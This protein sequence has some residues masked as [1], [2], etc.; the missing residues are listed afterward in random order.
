MAGKLARQKIDPNIFLVEWF[1]TI[2]SR[3]FSFET[4]L[5]LWDHLLYFGEV[6][7]YRIALSIMELIR[8]HIMETSYEDT[9]GLIQGCSVYVREDKLL[10][11]VLAHKL[12]N[13]KLWKTIDKFEKCLREQE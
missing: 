8:V 7:L 2:F 5:K 12:S 6:V 3:A 13:Q 11:L 10:E 9:I 4:T 1:Y